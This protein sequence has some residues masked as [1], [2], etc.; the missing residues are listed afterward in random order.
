MVLLTCS[1]SPGGKLSNLVPP[2]LV[3]IVTFHA[4][5]R[6]GGLA[7][8]HNHDLQKDKQTLAGSAQLMDSHMINPWYFR[9]PAAQGPRAIQGT[10]LHIWRCCP[11]S[12]TNRTIQEKSNNNIIWRNTIMR[13]TLPNPCAQGCAGGTCSHS[14]LVLWSQCPQ[15]FRRGKRNFASKQNITKHISKFEY[16]L[17]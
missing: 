8:N 11:K 17:E 2:V 7:T 16:I 5:D 9:M 12:P 1:A 13:T 10:E 6:L 15:G 4:A 3:E 14:G